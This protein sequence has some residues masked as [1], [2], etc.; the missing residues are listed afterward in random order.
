MSF[1]NYFSIKFPVFLF[2]LKTKGY[3]KE[4]TEFTPA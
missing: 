4:E 2:L 3:G 1:L